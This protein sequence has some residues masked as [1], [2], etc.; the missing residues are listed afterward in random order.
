VLAVSQPRPE[1]VQLRLR[2]VHAFAA[3]VRRVVRA[4]A[5]SRAV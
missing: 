2:K 4:S 3:A 5:A 1:S